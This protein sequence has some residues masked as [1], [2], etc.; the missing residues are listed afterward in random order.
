MEGWVWR[1][2]SVWFLEQPRRQICLWWKGK[3]HIWV[4]NASNSIMHKNTGTALRCRPAG[5]YRV[6][7]G[8]AAAAYAQCEARLCGLRIQDTNTHTH[9]QYFFY[10]FISSLSETRVLN[11]TFNCRWGST[12]KRTP[13]S[14]LLFH[15]ESFTS[16]TLMYL[17]ALNHFQRYST[18]TFPGETHILKVL[19]MCAWWY[20]PNDN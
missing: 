6:P 10:Q 16:F 4:W 8:Y 20:H 13:F 14:P 15:I 5:N 11:C 18:S 3:Q 19:R 1:D 17:R 12:L 2:V 9:T 7:S